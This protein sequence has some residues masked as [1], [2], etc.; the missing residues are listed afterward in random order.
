MKKRSLGVVVVICLAA[1]LLLAGGLI[2]GTKMPDVVQMKAPYEHTKSIVTF[3]HAKHVKD[4]KL[5]CG[6]CHH[7]D[8]GKART[9]M[10]EGD[11]AKTCFECH[12]KPGEL[13]GKKAEG[14]SKQEKLA[15]E[16]NAVHENCQ[17]CHREYNKAHKTKAAPTVC[18]GCHPKK[19]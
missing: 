17:G 16:A 14:L 12:N 10:K 19:K 18:T 9:E 11:E 7:D 2:A 5:A 3:D 4:Y 6:E 15:Y 8:K 13:K 1:T